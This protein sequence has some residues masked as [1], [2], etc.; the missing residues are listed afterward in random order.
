MNRDLWKTTKQPLCF[1]EPAVAKCNKKLAFNPKQAGVIQD[2]Q[3]ICQPLPF[4]NTD[5]SIDW[6]TLLKEMDFPKNTAILQGRI[7]KAPWFYGS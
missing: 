7:K 1:S 4:I 2:L 3:I 5:A 6:L